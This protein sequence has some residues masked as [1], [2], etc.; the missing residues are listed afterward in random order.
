MQIRTPYERWIPL[1]VVALAAIWL[2]AKLPGQDAQP[3]QPSAATNDEAAPA[4]AQLLI[5][6]LSAPIFR[7]STV[8]APHDSGNTE[9]LP[10][11]QAA[12]R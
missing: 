11:P 9:S 5:P 10:I 12:A 3:K 2:A 6:R 8:A 4:R 1:F 7:L